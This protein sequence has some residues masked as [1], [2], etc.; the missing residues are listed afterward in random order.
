MQ[1]KKITFF[2]LFVMGFP[3]SGA[4]HTTQEV[5]EI[6]PLNQGLPDDGR[7]DSTI[8]SVADPA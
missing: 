3:A 2:A 7:S 1:V 6:G 8:S 4:T 5:K